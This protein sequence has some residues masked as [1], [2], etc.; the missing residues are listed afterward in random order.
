MMA[1][2]GVRISW[3]MRAR[4]SL[5]ARVAFSLFSYRTALCTA[6]AN[7]FVCCSSIFN[8]AF[9][10]GENADTDVKNTAPASSF[11]IINGK[12]INDE[13]GAMT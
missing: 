9:V 3:L 4:K 11:L 1:F 2:N 5:F 7:W 12:R 13:N 10:I 8:S 6:T